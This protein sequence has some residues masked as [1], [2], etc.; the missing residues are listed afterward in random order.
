[1]PLFA[2]AAMLLKIGLT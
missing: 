2:I 1:M